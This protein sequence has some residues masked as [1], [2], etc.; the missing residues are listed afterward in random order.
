[1]YNEKKIED[2]LKEKQ[3]E[4]IQNP[5]YDMEV[6]QAIKKRNVLVFQLDADSEEF[7]KVDINNDTLLSDLLYHDLILLFID[8][9]GKHVYIWEGS[10]TTARQKFLSA[11][12]APKL[13]D[14]YIFDASI[15]SV[16]DGD[17]TL[18]FK[19]FCGL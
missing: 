10:K 3:K 8:M 11:R 14:Q 6:I 18:S 5:D 4:D 9:D 7:K 15:T 13:R 2:E 1:M 19:D 12:M 16:D 17:E